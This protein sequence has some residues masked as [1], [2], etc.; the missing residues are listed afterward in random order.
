MGS[1]FK[2]NGN[3]KEEAAMDE[4]VHKF[5]PLYKYTSKAAKR[6]DL[7]KALLGHFQLSLILEHTIAERSKEIRKIPL[8]HVNTKGMDFDDGSDLKFVGLYRRSTPRK[9]KSKKTGEIKIHTRKYAQGSIT[10]LNTKKGAIRI[11]I[12]NDV[13]SMLEF[14][15]IPAEKVSSFVNEKKQKGIIQFTGGY[16]SG[17]IKKF[18]EFQVE[19]FDDLVMAE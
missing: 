18:E 4:I 7:K 2:E 13:R 9:Y 10:N 6:D 17:A 1:V 16:E 8:I 12:W 11:I 3:R 19:T 15:F 14:Y 5:D